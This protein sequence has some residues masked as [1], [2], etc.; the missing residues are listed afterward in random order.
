MSARKSIIN[1]NAPSIDRSLILVRKKNS[2][3]T[4]LK[5]SRRPQLERNSSIL[6]WTE[7]LSLYIYNKYIRKKNHPYYDYISKWADLV[8]IFAEGC[9][10][11]DCTRK[12]VCPVFFTPC[13][14]TSNDYHFKG[15]DK[16]KQ[17]TF[18]R[19]RLL[20][21]GQLLKKDKYADFNCHQVR[22]SFYNT[23]C[24]HLNVFSPSAGHL[25]ATMTDFSLEVHVSH[26]FFF[27]SLC[28][29]HLL[30]IIAIES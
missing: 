20:Y 6:R 4:H 17:G 18:F 27:F 30:M 28:L 10:F 23:T 14:L 1:V 15:T 5:Y 13:F 16:K 12:K 29:H 21:V 22:N 26:L 7:L 2:S 25:H 9:T 24:M 19:F 11:F 8:R 3:K